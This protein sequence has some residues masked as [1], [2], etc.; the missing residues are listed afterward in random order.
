MRPPK[1]LVRDSRKWNPNFPKLV[2]RDN[3]EAPA[4]A[5]RHQ[6]E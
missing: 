3:S 4:T 2:G 1:N 6:V 5:D